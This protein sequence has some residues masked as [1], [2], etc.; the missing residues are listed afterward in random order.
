MR[1]SIRLL[2]AMIL[3]IG[4]VIQV[5]RAIIDREELILLEAMVARE[6]SENKEKHLGVEGQQKKWTLCEKI[7]EDSTLPLEFYLTTKKRFDRLQSS[8]VID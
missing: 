1:F 4:I 8:E 7:L 6:R 3:L 5:T 2:L